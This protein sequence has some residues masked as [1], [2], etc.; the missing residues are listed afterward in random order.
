MVWPNARRRP[1]CKC[2]NK[3]VKE[4]EGKLESF[5]SNTVPI[6]RTYYVKYAKERHLASK[7]LKSELQKMA[8]RRFERSKECAVTD[9]VGLI[10]LW[11]EFAEYLF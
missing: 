7:T 5:D 11:A 4:L 1:T 8:A 6:S 9:A 2:L 3:L 10:R